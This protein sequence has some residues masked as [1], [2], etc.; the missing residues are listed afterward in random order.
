MKALNLNTLVLALSLTV[1]SF[2]ATAADYA[3]VEVTPGQFTFE[4][5]APTGS[6]TDWVSFSVLTASD[7]IATVSGTSSKSFILSEF[8]LYD[9]SKNL[10][11]TG[12]IDNFFNKASLGLVLSGNLAGDYLLKVAGT[13]VGGTYNGNISLSPVPEPDSYAMMLAGLS[14][15]G[16]AARRRRD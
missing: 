9:S 3:A 8:S 15:M 2:T 13:T 4:N 11:A 16:F 6:F 14:L 5:T 7:L 10:I 12:D 1:Y